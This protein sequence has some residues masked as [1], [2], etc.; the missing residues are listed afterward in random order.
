MH[1]ALRLSTASRFATPACEN[2]WMKELNAE[3][4]RTRAPAAP[5]PKIPPLEAWLAAFSNFCWSC[6]GALSRRIEARPPA[7]IMSEAL[8][9]QV[10]AQEARMEPAVLERCLARTEV[11]DL[12]ELD[13][14]KL[15]RPE[16]Q[17]EHVPDGATV[18]DLRSRGEYRAW[19]WPDAL[20][21]DFGQAVRGY[22]GF[23]RDQRYVLYCEF[24]LKSAHLA[25]LMRREGFEA[26]HLRGGTRALK[27]LQ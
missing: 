12:R 8:H 24:G 1:T 4:L 26:F 19:H 14:D 6:L 11:F 9:R 22:P 21:L 13:P 18:I 5:R 16:L 2:A 27:R 20:W 3:A 7:G 17:I 15:E 25:D 23:D 10:E